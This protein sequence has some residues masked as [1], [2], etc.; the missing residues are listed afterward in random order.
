MDCSLNLLDSL[1][2]IFHDVNLSTRSPSTIHPLR[3]HHPNCWPQMF[4]FRQ[5]GTGHKFSICPTLFASQAS[6]SV[7]FTLE[8]LD[9]CSYH[10]ITILNLEIIFTTCVAF[11][12]II[13]TQFFPSITT[14]FIIPFIFVQ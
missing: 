8:W 10:Q 7:V 12:L 13:P 6:R 3:R 9:L 5:F 2:T 11:L 14:F 4:P 1:P